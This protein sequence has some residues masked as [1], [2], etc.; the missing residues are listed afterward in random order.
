MARKSPRSRKKANAASR[1]PGSNRPRKSPRTSSRKRA[2]RPAAPGRAAHKPRGARTPAEATVRAAREAAR[3]KATRKRAASKRAKAGRTESK[4]ATSKRPPTPA[5]ARKKAA[6]AKRKPATRRRKFTPPDPQRVAAILTILED[7]YPAP[8]TALHFATPLQLLIATI[9]SAQCT[10][11]RV[12]MVTPGLFAKYP[13]AKALAGVPQEELEQEIRSTGFYRN[14][15]KSIRACCAD[16]VA[17]HGGEVPRTMEALTALHGVGRKTANVVLGNAFGIPGLVVDTHV[18]RLSN[19]LGLTDQKDAV[20]IEYALMPIVPESK[21]TQF[22]HWLILH[23]RKVC[24]ARKP[25]CSIC[26]L[27]PH[28]PRIG[29]TAAQ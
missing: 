18:T 19:R 20:K 12:N 1:M 15:A 26:P 11:E 21:W 8:M 29:V 23:G 6:P 28:C 17:K 27:A 24:V 4:R 7:L 10:D 16:I 3:R 2:V 25:R 14:K 22:S 9:L 5:A 13:D